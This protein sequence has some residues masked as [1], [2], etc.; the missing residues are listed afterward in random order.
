MFK[1]AHG[2]EPS[3]RIDPKAP[4]EYAAFRREHLH[5][6]PSLYEERVGFLPL[7]TGRC[8]APIVT[9]LS[10]KHLPRSQCTNKATCVAVENKPRHDGK[11]G[12][13]EL[14]DIHRKQME[15]THPDAC[16]FTPLTS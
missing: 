12:A 6:L 5:R 4:D 16:H 7:G 1:N 3:P 9:R 14:C 13:M 10:L 8:H 11:L 15:L 2:Q